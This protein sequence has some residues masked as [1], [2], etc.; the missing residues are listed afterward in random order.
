[1]VE[2]IRLEE[3][4]LRPARTLLARSL[5]DEMIQT[6][7]GNF[8]A[9]PLAGIP[10]LNGQGSST[11][12]LASTMSQ[13]LPPATGA[14]VQ[15][16][17]F[18]NPGLSSSDFFLQ[19]A[20]SM[21]SGAMPVAEALPSILTQ[22]ALGSLVTSTISSVAMVVARG[23]GSADFISVPVESVSSP[24]PQEL[25]PPHAAGLIADLLPFDR[26]S[27]G[28]AVDRFFDQLEDLDL[29]MGQLVDQEP[30]R[31]IPF[32]LAVLGT[33]TALEVARRRLT[34]K[35]VVLKV[36]AGPGSRGSE[37][38]LGFPELPGSWSTRLT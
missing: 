37:Q 20:Q 25:P 17:A 16:A 26:A 10:L 18:P 21:L 22:N 1:M 7:P 15:L 12:P 13:A 6:S 2:R 3:F 5:L 33:V 34:S 23:Q 36:T 29:G 11:L 24:V 30:T 8:D 32:S 9:S 14:P 19:S 27:L 4:P 31:V 38:L 28:Q 35:P